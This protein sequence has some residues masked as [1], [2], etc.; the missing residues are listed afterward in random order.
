M[1]SETYTQIFLEHPDYF[2]SLFFLT[3][4][5]LLPIIALAPFFGAKLMPM[6]ARVG[7]AIALFAILFPFL[8]S[9]TAP[10][11]WSTLLIGYALKELLVG[12]LIGFLITIPFN[13]AQMAGI[14]ID[15]QR[16][17]SSMMGSDITT[18]SQVS[19]IGIL[20]NAILIVIFYSLDGPF[21]FLDA[22]V[23]SYRVLPPDQFPPAI[24]FTDG[25][26]SFWV[27][28]IGMM[29]KIFA[30]SAQLAAPAILAILMTDAFLGIINRLAPQVQISFLGQ[31]LKSFLGDF[32]VWLAWF[33]MLD[34]MGK[35]GINWIVTLSDF[36]TDLA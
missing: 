27:G 4:A 3:L 12:F 7:F 32:A 20:Y 19:T 25:A 22:V 10:I 16:G 26:S 8:V 35:I 9:K 5:R 11:P 28:I 23:K 13:I 1:N 15:N 18:G 17:S 30:I 31:G 36:V 29:G 33:F 6:P 2:G 21:L 34:Q 24:F 14:V